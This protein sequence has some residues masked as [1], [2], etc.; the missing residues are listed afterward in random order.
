[1]F[2]TALVSIGSIGF[3]GLLRLILIRYMHDAEATYSYCDK[4]I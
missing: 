4:V 3:G 2:V 1:M